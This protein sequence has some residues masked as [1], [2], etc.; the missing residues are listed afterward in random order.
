MLTDE[1]SNYTNL[2]GET[3]TVRYLMQPAIVTA[4][5]LDGDTWEVQG[6]WPEPFRVS[7]ELFKKEFSEL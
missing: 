6:P 1:Y 7:E 5:R 2:K 3:V 4:K